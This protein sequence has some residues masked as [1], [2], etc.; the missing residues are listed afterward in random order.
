MIMYVT[1]AV[2]ICASG[3][4]DSDGKERSDL[5]ETD[6]GMSWSVWEPPVLKVLQR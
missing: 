5:E 2:F 1:V 4:D 3:R 6:Q